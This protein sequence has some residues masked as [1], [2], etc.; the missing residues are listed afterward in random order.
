[1]NINIT[2]FGFVLCLC[3]FVNFSSI[4]VSSRQNTL[5]KWFGKP[6]KKS[7]AATES[8]VPKAKKAK[9]EEDP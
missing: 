7:E 4:K 2:A 9:L 5:L 8:G 1:M 3:L 6:S